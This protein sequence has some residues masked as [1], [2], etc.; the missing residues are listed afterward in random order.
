MMNFSTA[1][2]TTVRKC[3]IT[4]MDTASHS[5]H[6]PLDERFSFPEHTGFWQETEAWL[7]K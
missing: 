5:T 1:T 7:V 6:K 4:G 2:R 3:P